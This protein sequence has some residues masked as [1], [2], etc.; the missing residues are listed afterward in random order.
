M[1]PHRP[2]MMTLGWFSAE[3]LEVFVPVSSPQLLAI[4]YSTHSPT[5]TYFI[6]TYFITL[7]FLTT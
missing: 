3:A 4:S 7:F 2:E 6:T 5:S 1:Y